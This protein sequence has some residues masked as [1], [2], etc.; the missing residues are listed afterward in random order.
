ME[1]G[2]LGIGSLQHKICGRPIEVWRHNTRVFS[3]GR[4][5]YDREASVQLP[6]EQKLLR[7]VAES[8]PDEGCIDGF[9]CYYIC[10][11]W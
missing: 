6:I 5:I 9:I 2:F 3:M 1:L 10:G 7:R 11:I 4:E 8:W